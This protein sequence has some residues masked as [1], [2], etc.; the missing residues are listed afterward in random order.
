[1]NAVP[2]NSLFLA[3]IHQQPAEL[4]SWGELRWLCSEKQ[5][6]GALQTFGHCRIFPGH[7]NPMH[8]H[9]NCEELLYLVTG[10]GEHRFNDDWVKLE[11]GTLIRIP[12]FVRHCLRNTGTKPLECLISFSSGNRETVFLE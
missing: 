8:F 7:V 6:A 5:S 9:P 12:A 2:N 11:A 10:Q 4:F 1:M 3:N